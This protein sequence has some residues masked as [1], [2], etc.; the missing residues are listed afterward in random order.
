MTVHLA[1]MSCYCT[2]ATERPMTIWSSPHCYPNTLV[3]ICKE[4]A[5]IWR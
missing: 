3:F 1:V 4:V 2:M 5:E